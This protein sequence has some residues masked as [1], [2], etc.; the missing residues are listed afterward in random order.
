MGHWISAAEA[1]GVSRCSACTFI[2]LSLNEGR[3]G[4]PAAGCWMLDRGLALKDYRLRCREMYQVGRRT[5][6]GEQ[7]IRAGES[8]IQLVS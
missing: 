6:K 3:R 5:S 2:S 8:I 4:H 7:A 1:G